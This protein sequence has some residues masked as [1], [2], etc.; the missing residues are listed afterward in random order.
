MFL[1]LTKLSTLNA[2]DIP[3]S[4]IEKTGELLSK[5]IQFNVQPLIA[6]FENECQFFNES[7]SITKNLFLSKNVNSILIHNF[8]RDLS[9]QNK[10]LYFFRSWFRFNKEERVLSYYNVL[11]NLN[12]PSTCI[13][14]VS[15]MFRASEQAIYV[16]EDNDLVQSLHKVRL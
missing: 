14:T 15:Y 12:H 13:K 8:Y 7:D 3:I 2:N 9:T 16:L 5:N 6:S 10:N 11:E 4:I 1:R